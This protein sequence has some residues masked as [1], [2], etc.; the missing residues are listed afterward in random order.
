M[1]INALQGTE[2]VKLDQLVYGARIGPLE[3]A[4]IDGVHAWKS[5]GGGCCLFI[6]YKLYT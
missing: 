5:Y 1:Q 3:K 2:N 6:L 4:E